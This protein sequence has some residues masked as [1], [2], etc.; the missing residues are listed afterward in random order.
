MTG[1]PRDARADR[2]I[3]EA[4]LEL[5]VEQGYSRLT[6]DSVARRAGVARATV[7]RR[8]PSKAYLVHEVVFPESEDTELPETG[9]LVDD[10]ELF[11]H[12]AAALFARPEV[13]AAMPGLMA[14]IQADPAVGDQ[15]RGRLDA[16]ARE[17]FRGLVARAV[18][19]G[20]ATPEVDADVVFDTVVGSLVFS[21]LRTGNV[22][23]QGY[24]DEL[25]RL[26]TAGVSS[27]QPISRRVGP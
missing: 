26:M 18:E 2:A 23:R 22:Q 25:V 11:V 10:L 4:V 3:I 27:S 16:A 12:G 7:Y 17:R 15:L 19:R 9:N 5:L 8:W 6:M 24:V 1:R 20:A 14:E 13:L 21:L